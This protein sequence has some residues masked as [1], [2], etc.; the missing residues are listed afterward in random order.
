M[1]EILDPA[2]DSA[3][4]E[5]VLAPGSGY[6]LVDAWELAQS[7]LAAIDAFP[8]IDGA[9]PGNPVTP[10]FA[11][12]PWRQAV[13]KLPD[14]EQFLRLR[15]AR[16]RYLIDGGEQ[17]KWSSAL[18]G[19]AGLSVGASALS[20][21]ALTGARRFRLAD[22]D[23]LGFT[24]LNRLVGSVCDIGV[25]KL[26]IA[27]R[28]VLEA[29]PY[30]EITPF[31]AGYTSESAS[32][33][34]G[35]AGEP[36]SVL[37]E[38]MDDLAA[39]VDIRIR[40]RAARIPVVMATDNGDSAILDVER[41]DLDASYPLFHGRADR[42]EALTP[43][44]LEDQGERI[45][46]VGGIVGTDITPRTRYSL[47]QV[48]RTLPSWPQLGTAATIAGA[49]AAYAARLIV[50]GHALSSGRYRIDIDSAVLGARAG[51]AQRWNEL[52]EATFLET[53]AQR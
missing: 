53:L 27:Q 36:L 47:T 30:S 40:A 39:K 26:D 11:V 14:S 17:R 29:D 46:I 8:N 9:E 34:L 13:V 10:R 37:I 35:T 23:T 44:Q 28:R 16:N 19:I 52:D 22:H 24:N 33:F 5:A 21:C 51:R 6:T 3:Q 15:T 42:V 43:E 4:I 48:G 20:V 25:A 12:F 18:V 45:R 32:G 1:I 41:Y 2:T 50:C 7:E 49:A 38:E 31:H